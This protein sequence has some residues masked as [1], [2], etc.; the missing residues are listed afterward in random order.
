MYAFI[1]SYVCNTHT[2]AVYDVNQFKKTHGFFPLLVFGWVM[3][4]CFAWQFN[5]LQKATVANQTISLIPEY[6]SVSRV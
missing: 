5:V 4:L 3:K 6:K 1:K 2:N